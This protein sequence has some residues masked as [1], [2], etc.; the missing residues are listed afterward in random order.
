MSPAR[1]ART[2]SPSAALLHALRE[3]GR[4]L[5]ELAA[6]QDAP[7][8]AP[9]TAGRRVR[10]PAD[11]AAYLA[12]EMDGLEQEQ[13]RVVLLDAR[14]QIRRVVLVYQGT[15][16]CTRV[17]L[18]D[19]FREA[20][21]EGATA[22]VVVHNHPSG[23]PRPSPDD[24]RLT[25]DAARAGELLGVEVLDHIILGR[26][27]FT[28]LRAAGLYAPELTAGRAAERRRVTWLTVDPTRPVPVR[29]EPP[30]GMPQ[31]SLRHRESQGRAGAVE[32]AL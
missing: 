5:A 19:C 13:L 16:N 9:P 10:R 8:P 14:N 23:D 7:A 21:R 17:H 32:H 30:V 27:G 28:S 26:D 31:P 24:V 11:V 18:A 6:R 25:E 4:L 1:R 2:P 22:I 12:P 20:V 3:N 29:E 15:A